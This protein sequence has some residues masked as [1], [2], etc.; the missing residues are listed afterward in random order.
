MRPVRWRFS[1]GRLTSRGV[2]FCRRQC[3]HRGRAI[4]DVAGEKFMPTDPQ[5][6]DL[7]A[8]RVD[9]RMCRTGIFTHSEPG[10]MT[11]LVASS[12]L[13]LVGPTQRRSGWP[14]SRLARAPSRASSLSFLRRL[15]KRSTRQGPGPGGG[16]SSWR[17]SADRR[18]G[19]VV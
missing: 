8:A 15:R 7:Y 17:P 13:W 3:V 11:G 12:C 5:Q 16:M 2:A 1:H 6:H 14:F 18:C 4:N 19:T 9:L 10:G